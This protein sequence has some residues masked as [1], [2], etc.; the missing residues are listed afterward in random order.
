M[1]FFSHRLAFTLAGALALVERFGSPFA[2]P[3]AET[4][5]AELAW[6]GGAL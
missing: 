2:K 4:A 5:A 6:R 3:R 1:T